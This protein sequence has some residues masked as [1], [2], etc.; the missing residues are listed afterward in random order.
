MLFSLEDPG[1]P[2]GTHLLQMTDQVESLHAHNQHILMV[3][4][5]RSYAQIVNLINDDPKKIEEIPITDPMMKC[6]I[7]QII[8][9]G[10][11]GIY[12]YLTE[13]GIFKVKMQPKFS[14]KKLGNIIEK[15][16][17]QQGQILAFYKDSL[18]LGSF[19]TDQ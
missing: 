9:T 17:N 1:N 2:Q 5:V 18:L 12:A 13:K 14:Q 3:G 7:Y 8:K 6:H 16:G 11:P 4:Q 15:H 10:D 19:K